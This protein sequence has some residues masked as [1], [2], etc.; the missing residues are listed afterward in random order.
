[1]EREEQKK[2]EKEKGEKRE[3]RDLNKVHIRVSDIDWQKYWWSSLFIFYFTLK[4]K[5][6]K[7]KR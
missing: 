7:K 2:G 6:G 3:K 1:M 4:E 5:K